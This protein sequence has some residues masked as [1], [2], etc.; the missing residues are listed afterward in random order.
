MD[1]HVKTYIQENK[2]IINSAQWNKLLDPAKV[3]DALYP[4]EIEELVRI[5]QRV[6]MPKDMEKIFPGFTHYVEYSKYDDVLKELEVA[7]SLPHIKKVDDITTNLLDNGYVIRDVMDDEPGFEVKHISIGSDADM[8]MALIILYDNNHNA[9]YITIEDNIFRDNIVQIPGLGI[10]YNKY[11]ILDN[12]KKYV[13][14][15]K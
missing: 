3:Q 14:V 13:D 8:N 1:K 10:A 12:F 7:F 5:L 4:D 11:K 9:V 15:I 2:E 6:G